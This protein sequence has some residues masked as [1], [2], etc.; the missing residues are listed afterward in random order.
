MVW[1]RGEGQVARVTVPAVARPQ[2][3]RLKP[4][5]R[6]FAL[7]ALTGA[8]VEAADSQIVNGPSSWPLWS[9]SATTVL[10]EREGVTAQ[11]RPLLL[12]A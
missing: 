12:A 7:F 11:Q 4:V 8:F 10:L 1:S 9:W 2:S 6:L 3:R 5:L